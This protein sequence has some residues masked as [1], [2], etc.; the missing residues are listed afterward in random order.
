MANSNPQRRNLL[1]IIGSIVLFIAV[2]IIALL[3]SKKI[4]P[5]GIPGYSASSSKNADHAAAMAFDEK[6]ET[7]WVPA[8]K[9][10]P[11]YEWI[12]I[13]YSVPQIVSGMRMIN[14]FGGEKGNYRFGAK[15]HTARILL[16]DY[17]SYYWTLKEDVPDMQSISFE[18]NHEVQ[19]IKVFIHS[20]YKGVREP[21]EEIGI[22]EIEVF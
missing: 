19:W 7:A 4:A 10:D 18:K 9:Q 2:L 21:A 1:I 6:P 8:K 12:Q 3:P 15:V 14:G 5:A 13:E 17:A 11:R 20:I 22:A 16:S